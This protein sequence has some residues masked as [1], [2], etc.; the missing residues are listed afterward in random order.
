M[1]EAESITVN[2]ET[3]SLARG[4]T[5]SALVDRLGIAVRGIAI[6]RNGEVVPRSTW[7]CQVLASGDVV[8]IL[9]PAQGG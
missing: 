2:G 5:V 4:E 3:T 1:S 8:E 7:E 9:A 6:A